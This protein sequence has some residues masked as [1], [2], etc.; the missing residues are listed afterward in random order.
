MSMTREYR[1]AAAVEDAVQAI[2][3]R[4]DL[5]VELVN[6]LRFALPDDYPHLDVEERLGKLRK[7][8]DKLRRLVE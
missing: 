5:A 3:D 7:H 2:G 8:H 6:E 4:I 1:N